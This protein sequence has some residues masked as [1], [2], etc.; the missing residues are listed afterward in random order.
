MDDLQPRLTTAARADL[1]LLDDAL[2]A[3]SLQQVPDERWLQGN[4]SNTVR[5]ADLYAALRTPIGGPPLSEM[6]WDCFAPKKVKVFFWILRHGRT[7]TRASLHC[8][9]VLDAPDCPFCPGVPEEEDH[10]FAMCPHLTHLWGRLLPGQPPPSTA[11]GAA[12]AVGSLFPTMSPKIAHTAALAVLWIIWKAR[13]AM[14][15]TAARQEAGTMARTLMDHLRLWICRAPSKL[16][17]Q[18]LKLWCQTVIDVN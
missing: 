3:V 18:P 10:M 14:V 1:A 7:R 5:A 4:R 11:R 12:E 6:N 8:H 16:D 2:A 13:N 15:F 9:G 17:T